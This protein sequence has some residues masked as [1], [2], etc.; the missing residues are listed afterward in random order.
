VGFGGAGAAAA[1]EASKAGAEV[2][3]LERMPT[4]GG[5]TAICGGIVMMGG[6]TPVQKA[7]GQEDTLENMY[8]YILAAAGAGADAE[9]VKL[10]CDHSLDLFAWLV[11]LGIKFKESY[12][13]G[14]YAAPPTDDGLVYSG[15]EQQARYAAVAR[16]VP[17]GHHVQAAGSS[18]AVLW[19]PLQSGVEA[20]GAEVLYEAMGKELVVNEDGRVVGVVAEIEG[21]EQ[22][23]KANKA[24]ILTAGGFAAN[25]EMVARHCPMYLES[26]QTGTPGDDGSGILMGQLAGGDVRMLGATFAY[27]ATYIFSEALVKGIV[28]S[29]DNGRRFIGEDNYGSWVG[30]ALAEHHRSSF[31]IVDSAVWGEVPEAVLGYLPLAG[32]AD[33]IA[34]LATAL[35]MPPALLE[36]TVNSYNRFAAEGQDPE[37]LKDGHYVVPLETAPFYAV[38]F[39]AEFAAFFTT[40][41]L[42]INAKTQVLDPDGE[43]IPGL[44]S[45]GRNAFA[46]TAENYPGSGTSV[47]EAFTFGRIAGKNAAAEEPWK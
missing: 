21:E 36:D 8:N 1:I 25:K 3:V 34:E 17:R 28:V 40:G 19:P 27:W 32:Q 18:G 22:Y 41:G 44:Y 46:V 42:R 16:P 45:A 29:G 9:M 43:P 37:F 11:D 20:A 26:P 4:G 13:P 38:A 15:N 33:T 23:L 24:V 6:G 31:L 30:K 35:G 14:K 12:L 5:S 47:G 10:Y 2:L 7:T 39:G